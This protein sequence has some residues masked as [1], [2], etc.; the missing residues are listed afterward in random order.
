MSE[1]RDIDEHIAR[2]KD[3]LQAQLA[4][5]RRASVASEYVWLAVRAATLALAAVILVLL[6]LQSIDIHHDL[7]AQAMRGQTTQSILDNLNGL[8]RQSAKE[9][10]IELR[11]V[12]TCVIDQFAHSAGAA[13]P[14]TPL[15]PNCPLGRVVG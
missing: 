10:P 2:R 14:Y 13:L 5:G 9:T 7:R 12:E 15:P 4:K 11:Q 3:Q 6:I 8:E 1:Q